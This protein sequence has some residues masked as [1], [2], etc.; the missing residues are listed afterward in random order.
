MENTNVNTQIKNA[1]SRTEIWLVF[2]GLLVGM[3]LAALDQTIVATALPTIVSD[4]GGLNQL[5]W[6]VTA[7]LLASTASTP[8]WGKIGDLF[9][10]KRIFQAAIVIFLIG[11]AASGLSENMAEL[12]GFRALQ[13][14][15]AGG[16]MVTAMAI[17]GDIVSSRDRGRYQGI[18]GAVFGVSSIAGPLLGGYIVQNFSW[19]WVFYINVP[20][21]LIALFVTQAVL[22]RTRPNTHP[23]IDYLGTALIAGAATAMVLIASLGGVTY[24]WGSPFIISLA[25]A[26]VVLI[27]AFIFVEQHSKEPVLPLRLFRNSVFTMTSAIGFIV[28]FA[29]FGAITFLPLYL[30]VVQRVTPTDSGLRMLPMLAGM[31]LTSITSGQLIS[32]WGRYKLFPIGGTAVMGAGLYLLSLLDVNT[33][34][35]SMSI[36]MFVM[37]LGLGMVMQ[38]LIIAVQNAVEFRDLGTATSGATFFRSIGGAFGVAVFGEIFANSLNTNLAT[39]LAS[40]TLPAGFNPRAA[41]SSPQL[42]QSLPLSVIGGYLHAFALS[43]HNVFIYAIPFAVVGFVLSWFLKETPLRMTINMGN[44]EGAAVKAGPG[45]AEGKTASAAPAQPEPSALI[46]HSNGNGRVPVIIEFSQ[47]DGRDRGNPGDDSQP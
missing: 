26:A 33:T 4:L 2:S 20:I 16:L 27:I 13:G 37:G 15:G 43:L 22:P 28:G 19:H 40:G 31:L 38:V 39:L 25:V 17:V 23:T 45:Q 18:F 32:R 10:R 6:V 30:Q 1:L 8:L 42:L 9:G 24:A 12:I 14:L 44:T 29:M 34:S 41:M 7:Y 21:G 35:L 46:V 5:S 47:P 11:S 3:L 36:Y